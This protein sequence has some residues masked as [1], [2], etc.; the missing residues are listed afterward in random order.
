MKIIPP[1]V[2]LDS[3]LT[4]DK[5]HAHILKK[6]LLVK[7]FN[8]ALH[9]PLHNDERVIAI[10]SRRVQPHAQPRSSRCFSRALR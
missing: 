4:V 6:G 3:L 1:P 10:E 8:Q 7:D 5:T 9:A 2:P